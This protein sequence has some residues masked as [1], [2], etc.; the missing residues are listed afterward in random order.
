M[1]ESELDDHQFKP[2][3]EGLKFEFDN[4]GPGV[5]KFNFDDIGPSVLQSH[6][7]LAFKM[8][9]GWVSTKMYLLLL[10]AKSVDKIL[11]FLRCLYQSKSMQMLTI[12]IN[13]VSQTTFDFIFGQILIN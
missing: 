3:H 11:T 7:E 9:S 5:L 13:Q 1:E 4:I 12:C 2:L 10:L 6:T 8:S